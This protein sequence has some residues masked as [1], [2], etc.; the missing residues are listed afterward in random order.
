MNQVTIAN[1]VAI[2]QHSISRLTHSS[3]ISRARS[4]EA[5]KLLCSAEAAVGA[6]ARAIDTQIDQRTRTG[7]RV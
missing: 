2:T 7:V 6:C 5:W 3:A 4:L 1:K